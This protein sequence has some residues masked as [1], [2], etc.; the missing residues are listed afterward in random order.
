[1]A[2]K[3]TLKTGGAVYIPIEHSGALLNLCFIKALILRY[4]KGELNCLLRLLAE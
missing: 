2:A 4:M 3:S 1:M